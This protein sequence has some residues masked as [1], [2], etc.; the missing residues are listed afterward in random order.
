MIPTFEVH[1]NN[2]LNHRVGGTPQ[3]YRDIV[4]LT[5]GSHFEFKGRHLLGIAVGTPVTHP[6]PVDFEVIA[7]FNLRF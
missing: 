2:P 7:S 5:I 3:V 1:V 6:R 4:D